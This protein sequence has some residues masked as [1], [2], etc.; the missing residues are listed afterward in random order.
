MITQ[1]TIGA[2][3]LTLDQLD[4]VAGG[5]ALDTIIKVV[6]A[7]EAIGK[8]PELYR[9][10]KNWVIKEAAIPYILPD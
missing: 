10:A 8:I 1:E 7:A 2:Q 4:E 3:E 9:R 6:E 5:G